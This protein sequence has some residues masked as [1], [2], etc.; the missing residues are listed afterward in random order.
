MS[1]LLVRLYEFFLTVPRNGLLCS[2]FPLF[3]YL[4][5]LKFAPMGTAPDRVSEKVTPQVTSP[6]AVAR[7]G[8]LWEVGFGSLRLPNPTS[9]TMA[10]ELPEAVRKQKGT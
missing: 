10:C 5:F 1:F 3:S 6:P 4:F 7:L 2:F 8:P 9:H